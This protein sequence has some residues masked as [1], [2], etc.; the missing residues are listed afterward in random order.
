[1]PDT[2]LYIYPG[3]DRYKKGTTG[4]RPL[5][6]AVIVAKKS[7]LFFFS[8]KSEKTYSEIGDCLKF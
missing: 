5:K 7:L 6:A 3:S 8:S 4:L 2:T 1:M